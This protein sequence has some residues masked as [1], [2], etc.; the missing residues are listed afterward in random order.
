MVKDTL[1]VH[2]TKISCLP[3]VG[4]SY[5]PTIFTSQQKVTVSG[6]EMELEYQKVST[7]Q[8]LG[9]FIY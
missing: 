8:T 1:Y 9:Y 7:T 4:Y 3:S 6:S 5:D 2:K